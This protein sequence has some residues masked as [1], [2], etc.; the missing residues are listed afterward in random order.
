MTNVF[1][2][3]G[4]TIDLTNNALI[5]SNT[6]GGGT[7]TADIIRQMIQNGR[8][9]TS[10]N[11]GGHALGYADNSVLNRTTFGGITGVSTNSI[12]VAY[13]F[14]GDTNLDGK[15]NLLDLNPIATNFGA[16]TGKLWTDGD[17]TYDAAVGIDDF[18]ALALNYGKSMPSPGPAL[19]R[20][21]SRA[22]DRISRFDFADRAGSSATDDEFLNDVIPK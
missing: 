4:G 6:A 10:L 9:T 17:V 7:A 1:A 15:V 12:L 2:E 5:A 8:L 14:A 18:N 19:K 20:F 22:I 11:T 21:G 3:A 13:T 16:T